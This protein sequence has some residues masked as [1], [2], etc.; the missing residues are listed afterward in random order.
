MKIRNMN[1]KFKLGGYAGPVG[2][3][4]GGS[5][6]SPEDFTGAAPPVSL[7]KTILKGFNVALIS[8][9]LGLAFIACGEPHDNTRPTDGGQPQL[10]Y[11]EKHAE[12]IL[13]GYQQ[14]CD[15]WLKTHSNNSVETFTIWINEHR[16]VRKKALADSPYNYSQSELKGYYARLD[17]I[18]S[19]TINTFIK[20]KNSSRSIDILDKE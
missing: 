13:Y 5:R 10:T 17:K 15:G 12:D 7:F 19:D 11:A 9:V 2:R 1:G 4:G 6:K 20:N 18:T 8:A 3:G 14:H 16:D